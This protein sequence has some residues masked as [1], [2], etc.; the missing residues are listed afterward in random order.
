M[1]DLKSIDDVVREARA[2]Y[3]RHRHVPEFVRVQPRI[4]DYIHNHGPVPASYDEPRAVYLR[5]NFRRW[6]DK[7]LDRVIVPVT[8]L[9]G[10][11]PYIFALA[12]A[13]DLW[14]LGWRAPRWLVSYR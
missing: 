12:C 10:F 3:D 4:A 9:P 13:G 8:E 5:E 1:R 6:M 14:S 2:F 7:L 11:L